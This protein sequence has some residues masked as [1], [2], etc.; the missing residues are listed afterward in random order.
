MFDIVSDLHIDQWDPTIPNLYPCG[1][2]SNFPYKFVETQSEYLIIAGDISDNLEISI[3]YLDF[4]AKNT[5]YK[6]ILFVDGNHEHIHKYP[7]LYT[8]NEINEK[9]QKLQN[10]KIIYLPKNHFFNKE[11]DTV[12]IGV[13]GWWD[14]DNKNEKSIKD[15]LVY[16][17][18]WMTH[19]TNQDSEDFINN[20]ISRS[21]EEYEELNKALEKYTKDK[22]IKNIIIVTHT[23]PKKKFCNKEELSSTNTNTQYSKLIEK[24][25]KLSHWIFGHTHNTFEVKCD[26]IHFICNPRGRPEDF[27]RV[28][29]NLKS[30]KIKQNNQ[31]KL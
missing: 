25:N 14:Y 17:Q 9:I 28:Q 19:L 12:F 2:V 15:N 16:F 6:K 8:Q 7:N 29:Y 18:Q 10:D 26:D 4:L 5:H 1:R 11:K 31:A 27:D 22:N 30:F 23:C 3:K 21:N 13:C 20:I 24:Y